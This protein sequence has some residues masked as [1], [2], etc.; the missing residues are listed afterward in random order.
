MGETGIVIVTY[1]SAHEIADCVDAAR[2][3]GAEVVVV[4]NASQDESAAIARAH[5][6]RVISNAENRG[7]AAG[8]N[9]AVS[10][11]STPFVLILNPDAVILGGL[12]ALVAA[13]SLP[14]AGGSTGR[15]LDAGGQTQRGFMVRNFPT[16]G[17]LILEALLLNRIWPGNPWN[18]RYRALDWDDSV[19]SK[20]AQ[21][22]GA[23]LM[24]TRAAWEAAGGMDEGYCPL[25]FEDVDFCERLARLGYDLYYVPEAVARHAG[26]HSIAGLRLD[27]RNYYWYRSLLRY[28]AKHFH[29]LAF[30]MVALAVVTGSILRMI[31]PAAPGA[32]SGRAAVYGRPLRLALRCVVLGWTERV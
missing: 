20:V 13:A 30:R 27:V 3:T 11:L 23:F 17:V 18:R 2:A 9:Q 8:V 32:A 22:A 24:V 1:N 29:P 31:L 19:P 16:P 21:P 10:A 14:G 6:A 7:F 5:G 26:G 12:D 4:D 15:L 28:S 25:W